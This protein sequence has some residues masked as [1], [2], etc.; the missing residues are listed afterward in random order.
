M[1]GYNSRAV[2]ARKHTVSKYKCLRNIWMPPHFL[3]T[4]VLLMMHCDTALPAQH[5]TMKNLQFSDQHAEE[6]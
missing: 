5:I 1:G 2:I 3:H 4:P 6:F